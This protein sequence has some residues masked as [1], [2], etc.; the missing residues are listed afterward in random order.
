MPSGVE[1][2]RRFR[3]LRALVVGD[4]MLDTYLE[5]TAARL[6][7]EGPVPVVQ[8]RAEHRLPGGAA[9]TA[10]NLRALGAEVR[11]VGLVG[12]DLPGGLLRQAL[13]ERGVDDCWLVED[14]GRATLHKLRILADGQYVVRVDEGDTGPAGPA[15]EAALLAKLEAAY[16][17]SDLVLVSDYRYGVVG[18]ALIERLC[19]LRAARPA[20][21]LVD[22][23][24]LARFGRA[25]ATIVTPNHLEAQVLAGCGAEPPLS[26]G[27]DGRPLHLS[28]LAELGRRVLDRLDA[29]QVAITLGAAGV[30]LMP[31]DGAWIHLPAHP[32]EGADDV[33]AGD[34]FA[35]AC[36]LALAAGAGPVAAA[37]LGL[38]AAGI[39]VARRRTAAVAQGELLQR[40]SLRE[41]A[42]A[43]RQAGGEGGPAALAELAAALA[44][45]RGAGRTIVF[46]NGVFDI[47]HAGHVQFL[48]RA[49][50]LGDV[51]VVGVNSDRG[52][53]ALKGPRRPVTAE[54]DR[55]ALVGALGP[56][57]HVIAF[58]EETPAALIRAL[59]PHIHVKGGD[60]A[61]VPLPEAEAVREVG[62][63]VEIVPLA[64]E[65]STSRVI[66]RI[67]AL[68]RPCGG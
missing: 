29:E 62:G 6:C 54:R 30:L 17:E 56:V 35:A 34:S 14:A 36:A 2:V 28:E 27:V 49:K 18:A 47:L 9:N 37:Q 38:D 52:A 68:G 44:T 19:R 58:D 22:S 15:A 55:L 13:A 25:G 41:H 53:R 33:G 63:R 39:A 5:G 20:V 48:R 42:A 1:L 7:S 23:K 31:R 45:E 46:T 12:A 3:R 10:V 50:A 65:H 60:Y 24:D 32:V 57:D 59:R 4:A 16:A 21:L 40:V 66:E 61:D 67:A 51:L 26:L 43:A 11:F 64:G 8:K